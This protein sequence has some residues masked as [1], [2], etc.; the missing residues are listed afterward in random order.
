MTTVKNLYFRMKQPCFSFLPVSSSYILSSV[1]KETYSYYY[2]YF[3]EYMESG[4]VSGK[5]THN[6]TK[7]RFVG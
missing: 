7:C 5:K 6:Q 4:I 2:G 1:N 3:T